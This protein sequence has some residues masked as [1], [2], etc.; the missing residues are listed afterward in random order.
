MQDARWAPAVQAA[1]KSSPSRSPQQRVPL[2]L[3]GLLGEVAQLALAHAGLRVLARPHSTQLGPHE[4][5]LLG[6][7]R[8][9]GQPPATQPTPSQTQ[10]VLSR[11]SYH[12]TPTA[13]ISA[14]AAMAIH[15]AH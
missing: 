10:K 11:P 9:H 15:V 5:P 14:S 12:S 13:R 2:A 6:A 7:H 8:W 4:S 3:L 1:T